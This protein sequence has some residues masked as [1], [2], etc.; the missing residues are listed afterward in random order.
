LP[1]VEQ[2]EAEQVPQDEPAALLNFP[3]TEK[4]KADITR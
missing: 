4:A 2:V 1:Q 3:P